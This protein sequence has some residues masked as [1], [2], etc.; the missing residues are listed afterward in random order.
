M[1]IFMRQKFSR[2]SRSILVLLICSLFFIGFI[3]DQYQVQAAADAAPV[4]VEVISFAEKNFYGRGETIRFKMVY[5]EQSLKEF[6]ASSAG[7]T[8]IAF[9]PGTAYANMMLLEAT[10]LGFD[11]TD[12]MPMF[13]YT[14]TPEDSHS[15]IAVAGLEITYEVTFTTRGTE[16]VTYYLEAEEDKNTVKYGNEFVYIDGRAPYV[17]PSKSEGKMDGTDVKRDPEVVLQDAGTV[18]DPNAIGAYFYWTTDPNEDYFTA[19]DHNEASVGNPIPEPERLRGDNVPEYYFGPLYLLIQSNYYHGPYYQKYGPYW[20]DRNPPE[21]SFH[22]YASKITIRYD[23]DFK[24]FS[25]TNKVYTGE[26]EWLKYKVRYTDMDG[27]TTDFDPITIHGEDLKGKYV[28]DVPIE[29]ADGTYQVLVKARD[30]VGNE[31]YEWI[32]SD[33]IVIDSTVPK[34]TFISEEPLDVAREQHEVKVEVSGPLQTVGWY[35]WTQD[36]EPPSPDDGRWIKFLSS[37][38]DLP[39]EHV[40]KT[41][42]IYEDGIWYLHVLL[43]NVSTGQMYF[44]PS[45]GVRIDQTP[46]QLSFTVNGTEQF[47]RSVVT[48]V[49]VIEENDYTISYEITQDHNYD[50]ECTQTTADGFIT[51]QNMTGIYYI[52]VCVVDEAGHEVTRF[53]NPFFLDNEAPVATIYTDYNHNDSDYV[54][55]KA[56]VWLYNVSDNESNVKDMQIRYAWEE[57]DLTSTPWIPYTD[58]DEVFPGTV[59]KEIDLPEHL[60]EGKHTLYVQISDAA[61]NVSEVL[62]AN[63]YVDWTAPVVL[64]DQIQFSPKGLTRYPVRA[65][66]PYVDNID[67]EGRVQKRYEENGTYTIEISDRA[68]NK[69]EFELVIDQIDRVPPVIT[70]EP[71]GS[72]QPQQRVSV[73]VKVSDDRTDDVFSDGYVEARWTQDV[74]GYDGWTELT[75]DEPMVLEGVDG[76]WYLEVGAEDEAGNFIIKSRPFLLDNTPPVGTLTYDPPTRT[77]SPV[78]VTLSVY[79]EQVTIISPAD[80]SNQYTFTENGQ[81]LFEFEDEAGN[82]GEALAVVDWIDDSLPQASVTQSPATWTTEPVDVTVNVEGHPPRQLNHI[83]AVGDAEWLSAKTLEKGVLTPD[84]VA[85]L[86][87]DN[88]TVVESVYRFYENGT[89][90]YTIED[91]DTGIFVDTQT[92]IDHIDRT[93]PVATVHYST[94]EWTN[95]HGGNPV[96][97]TLQMSDNSG[98]YPEVISEGGRSIEFYENGSH[99]FVIQDVAGNQ[100]EVVATV[101]WIDNE[102]PVPHVRFSEET[103]TKED[104]TVEISFEDLTP[105][106]ILN[107]GHSPT[108]TF[109]ENG[110]FTFRYEDAAGNSGEKTVV[111]DWI[112]RTP[113]TGIITYWTE[114]TGTVSASELGWTNQTVIAKVELQ[115]NSGLTPVIISEGGAEHIFTENGTHTFEFVD[116]AGN[117]GQAIA[118]VNRI[119]KEPAQVKIYYSTRLPTNGFVRASLQADEPIIVLNNDGNSVYDFE[120]NGTFTFQYMDRAGNEGTITADVDWIDQEPPQLQ[121]VYSDTEPTSKDVIATV[122]AVNEEEIYVLNNFGRKDYVFTEN[123]SFN[124]IVQDRAGNVAEVEAVVNNIDKSKAKITVEYSETEMTNQPVTA[125]IHSDRELTVLNN[126]GSLSRIFDV[127]GTYVVEAVDHLHNTYRILLEVWNIDRIAPEFI[128][129]KPHLVFNPD[130][131]EVDLLAGMA[132]FDNRDGDI[133][134]KIEVIH[135]IDFEKSGVHTVTYRVQDSVGNISETQRFV[136][137]TYGDILE[138]YIND[139][140]AF[141][142]TMT[143]N[144]PASH[145]V[146]SLK[147]YGQQGDYQVRYVKGRWRLGAFKGRGQLLEGSTLKVTPGEYTILIEDQERQYVHI[148]VYVIY[149][150]RD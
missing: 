121:V 114:R 42:F 77:A 33:P 124:F 148:P 51:L 144:V 73:I 78:T 50:G 122:T 2:C 32:E 119:D 131:E 88:L 29:G 129:E 43:K 86:W 38:D 111:V 67:G 102:P 87:E 137:I 116:A 74:K 41:N 63:V 147:W 110:Q 7:D 52:K 49:E 27:N 53:S 71:N 120:E 107:N 17:I 26:V 18:P 21:I 143:V 92:I 57:A 81:F 20:V 45:E 85:D 79:E 8:I 69:T 19:T 66:I 11:E 61:G 58:W 108:Y 62:Q 48:K 130:E 68:G 97:A 118:V 145:P 36:R 12:S 149:N 55:E 123:G 72:M 82:R 100:T 112:D 76:V 15:D 150:Y 59:F 9:E 80:G 101:D 46:P 39:Y 5:D 54:R 3:P 16:S 141:E 83:R 126:G 139:M 23:E 106:T 133:S 127:N 113:P 22:H 105:V 75:P 37:D 10:F 94:T 104:V 125:V 47:Q 65:T 28:I 142:D 56:K 60:A 146:L 40:F 14:V 4:K 6:I 1:V 115:D 89:L 30:T 134:D 135:D 91:L 132:A 25:E 34:A 138:L 84:N 24:Y 96:I 136:V 13:E 93:P 70:F 35:Q 44:Y 98:E 31:H 99:T 64:E 117:I 128:I 103:W 90:Y 95:T 109:T 140:L